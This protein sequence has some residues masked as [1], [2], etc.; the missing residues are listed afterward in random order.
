ML[1][2]IESQ[3]I[4]LFQLCC[5]DKFNNIVAAS[6]SDASSLGII[7]VSG[8]LEQLVVVVQTC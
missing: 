7:D 4:K 1:L 3:H 5:D 8:L 6:F 2:L